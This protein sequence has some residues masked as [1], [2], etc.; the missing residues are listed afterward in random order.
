MV[1]SDKI[2][3]RFDDKVYPE[4]NTGCWLWGAGIRG[5]TG[6]GA[7]KVN[8]KTIDA[9]RVSFTIHKGEI[10]KGFLVCHKC[11]NRL[12]VNPDHLFLGTHKDNH[13]DAIK[14]GRMVKQKPIPLEQSVHGGMG[15]ATYDKGCRCVLC[16]EAKR[17]R[18]K[19]YRAKLKNIAR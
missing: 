7:F 15:A 11:D 18:I 17:M 8:D 2:I 3:K 9:H 13:D 19:N 14:K 6:Y 12:C 5:K 4:P 10:P 16:T 1:L